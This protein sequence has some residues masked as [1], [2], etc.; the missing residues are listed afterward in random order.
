MRLWGLHWERV[1]EKHLRKQGL[2]SVDKNYLC[3]LGEI[4]LIMRE[5]DCLVFIE[6]KYRNP[7]SWV[8]AAE[9]VTASKQKKLI[10]T[11]QHYLMQHPNEKNSNCRFDVVSIEGSRRNPRIEWFVNAFGI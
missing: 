5:R 6:V 8:R 4:D 3:K 10:M 7:N 9:T 2:I 11:A 1:A